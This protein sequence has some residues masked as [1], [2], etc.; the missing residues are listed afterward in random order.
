MTGPQPQQVPPVDTGN[1]LLAETPAQLV[2]G[3]VDTPAG[4]RLAVQ[5]TLLL[6]ADEAKAL[7]AGI[8]N[9]AASMST[10]GLIIA[11]GAMTP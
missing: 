8:A 7:A 3:L 1:Q 2:T 6:A 9:V 4:Q 10:T 11:N 5:V